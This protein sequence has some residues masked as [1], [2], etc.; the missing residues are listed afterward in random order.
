MPQFLCSRFVSNIC[1]TNVECLTSVGDN[2]THTRR[3]WLALYGGQSIYPCNFFASVVDV[4]LK[5]EV[6]PL[7]PLT[8][9]SVSLA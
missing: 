4:S 9:T 7:T 6:F 8:T 2:Q 5:Q 1:G 3:E